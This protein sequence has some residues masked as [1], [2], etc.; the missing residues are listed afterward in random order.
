[1]A[2]LT[3]GELWQQARNGDPAALGEIYLRHA[4]SVHRFCLWRIA[5]KQLAEDVSATV[6]GGLAGT[7]LLLPCDSTLEARRPALKASCSGR[8]FSLLAL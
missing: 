1:M 5:A 2:T 6:V 4:P 7:S 3:D 8:S